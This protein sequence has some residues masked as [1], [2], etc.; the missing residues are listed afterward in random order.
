MP[1]SLLHQGDSRP[2]CVASA[3]ADRFLGENL[4]SS[5]YVPYDGNQGVLVQ[6]FSLTKFT[7]PP[8]FVP[9]PGQG[10]RKKG[11]EKAPPGHQGSPCP[12]A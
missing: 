8:G 11:M 6:L 10:A 7:K 3:D 9:D 12:V 2:A 4:G 1:V 5:G